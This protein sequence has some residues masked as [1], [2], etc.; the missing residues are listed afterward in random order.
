LVFARHR[1]YC[2]VPASRAVGFKVDLRVPPRGFNDVYLMKR[3][4]P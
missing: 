2:A 4:T 1:I 3:K